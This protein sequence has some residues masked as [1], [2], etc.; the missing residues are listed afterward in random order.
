MGDIDGIDYYMFVVSENSIVDMSL[1]GMSGNVNLKL[2]D[3]KEKSLF[4]F[5]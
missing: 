5:L 4:F 3:N 2:F 1:M